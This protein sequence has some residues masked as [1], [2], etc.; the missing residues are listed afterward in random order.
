MAAIKKQT[1][2]EGAVILAAASIAVKVIGAMFKIPLANILDETGMAAFTTAY[3]LY[4]VLFVVATAGLPVAVSKMVSESVA[5]R[6]I[7][8]AR[9][10]FRAAMTLLF[11]IGVAGT[12]VLCLGARLF[13]NIVDSEVSYLSILA[14]SP[15]VFFVAITSAFRGYFQGF[16]NMTPTALSEI[17][18]A[19]GKLVVGLLL[20]YV[21]LPYGVERASA[22]AVLG[23]TAGALLACLILFVTYIKNHKRM[24]A[25]GG[26][27]AQRLQPR[28]YRGIYATLLK[29]AIPI[30]IGA[31]VSSL[32][33][34][35]DLV[36]IRQRLHSLIV[37][38]ELY[39]TLTQ[40]FG[41]DGSEVVLGTNMADTARDILYGCYSGYAVPMFNLPPTIVTALSMSVVPAVAGAYA[42][43]NHE[44]AR[45]LT[46]A[47][48]RITALF[49]LPC[50]VGMS[51]L[52]QPILT[53]VYNNARAEDMLA[54]LSIA[55]LFVCLV[56]VTT[57]ILQ[58]TGNVMIPVFNMLAGGVVK[59][60]TNYIL[61]GIPSVNIGGA[62]FSTVLCYLTIA[63]LN[64]FF[65]IRIIKPRFRVSELVI[66]P[67][68][69]VAAM[70]AA[71]YGV[72]QLAAGLLGAP[73]LGAAG[74][75]F[76]PSTAP[77]TPVAGDVRLM[78]LAALAAAIGAGGLVYVFMLFV[79][80]AIKRDD[81]V[82]LP[83][84][85]KL[86]ALLTRIH[87]L[88]H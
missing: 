51:L 63:A 14:I 12:L 68:L 52:S 13:V 36:M 34:V 45:R 76:L 55:V 66:K 1:Y 31:A 54:V 69:C 59:I 73:L 21:L 5:R 17:A 44:Q 7:A 78:T 50:A 35:I 61:I 22:G 57:A 19:A 80:G 87:L 4:A 82:M 72:Y 33:N 86:A 11:F 3:N 60:A 18:E 62:P 23:V 64:L 58:A 56:S 8:Q 42:L 41:I 43:H 25:A 2:L 28:S 40:Y 24:Q 37:T 79:V 38:P 77:V 9:R 27:A 49:A 15:A 70:G 81:I 88:R 39:R 48:V 84:G 67:L 71:A 53:G 20:V 74:L 85:E 30:T 47:T 46:E 75:D 10:I 29:I 16:S 65:I 83:K 32:T 6:D 26:Y